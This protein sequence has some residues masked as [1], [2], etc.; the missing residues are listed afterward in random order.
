VSKFHCKFLASLAA[1]LVSAA[2]L[3][4]QAQTAIFVPNITVSSSANPS[5]YGAPL[6]FTVAVTSPVAG[7]QVPTGVVSA[8]LASSPERPAVPGIFSLGGATL[9][10]NGRAQIAVPQPP[11]LFAIAPWGLGAGSNTIAFS[12]SGDTRYGAEQSTFTQFVTLANTKTTASVSGTAQPITLSATVAINEPSATTVAFAI[13]GESSSAPTGTVQFFNGAT[14]VGTATLAPAALFTSTATLAA[15]VTPANLT[16]VY[17]GDANFNPS[18]SA[19]TVQPGGGVVNLTVTS[20]ADP[21]VF[22]A[23]VT[24]SIAA[25]STVAAAPIPTGSVSASLFGL[26]GLGSV[27]LDAAGHGSLAVPPS[28]GGQSAPWGFAAQSNSVTLT[29]SGDSHYAQAQ[30]NFTQVVGKA[31]TTTAATTQVS[32]TAA[33]LSIQATVSINEPSVTSIGFALPGYPAG[34]ANP[35]GSVQFVRNG[36]VVGTAVLSPSGL[37]QSTATLVVTP[38]IPSAGIT[39]VYSGDTNYNGSTSPPATQPSQGVTIGVAS[40][41]NP[42]TFAEPVTFSVTVSP[43]VAGGAVPTGTVAATVLGSD[44]LASATLDATGHAT[45]TVPQTTSATSLPWGLATGTNAITV[46]Y[47]G[48][49]NYV[50]AQTAFNEIVNKANTAT[51]ISAPN[52]LFGA[53]PGVVGVVSI[54]E[55]PVTKNFAI[56]GS[57]NPITNPTGNVA[58]YNGTTLL[59]TVTLSPAELFQST[60][61]LATSVAPTSVVYSGDINYNSSTWT[62]TTPPA[63]AAVVITLASSANPV[64]YGAALTIAATVS[65]AAAGGPTPTGTLT[66][67]DGSQNLG[68][69]A[70]LDSTGRGTMPIPEPLATPL[71]CA[72][73]CPTDVSAMVLSAGSHTITV[74][75]SGDANYRAATSSALSPPVSLVQQI[76]KAPTA[77]AISGT[78]SVVGVASQC[79][80]AASVADGQPPSGGPYHFMTMGASGM[81]DGDPSG[82]V[83]FFNGSTS[84]GTATLSPNAAANVTSTA[85]L[86]ATSAG[87][88]AIYSG[89]ANFQSSTYSPASKGTV[90]LVLTSSPNPSTTGQSV[91]LT[92]TFGVVIA[93]FTVVLPTGTVAFLDG[94]TL[95]GLATVSGTTASLTTTL[96]TAFSTAGPHLLTASYS[97]DA[98]YLATSSASYGQIVNPQSGTLAALTLTANPATAVYGQQIVFFARPVGFGNAPPQGSVTLLDGTTAIGGGEFDLGTAE[99]IVTLPVGTHQLT[100]VWAGDGTWPAAVSPVLSYLVVRAPTVINLAPTTTGAPGQVVLAATVSVPLPG[101]G[102]PTGTVQFIDATT[103][104]V[105]GQASLNGAGATVTLPSASVPPDPIAAVYSGDGNFAPSTTVPPALALVAVSGVT[106]TV[107]APDEI[108]TI[109][110]AN[111]TNSTATGTPPLATSLGGVSVTV[112]D[113]AGTS[114]LAPLYYASPG[115][116]N[117]VVPTGTISGPATLSVAGHSLPIGVTPVSPNLFKVSQVV[118]VLPDGTQTIENTAAPIVFGGDSLYLVLYGTG[119]RN[120]SSLGAVTCT[121]GTLSLPVTYAGPQSQ[122]P[123]LDQVVVPLPASLQGAGAVNAVV[124]ADG[125]ASN[126]VSLT[127]Q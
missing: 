80:V 70:S 82:A 27:T 123:G 26:F 20:S 87:T 19:A 104:A 75:Y 101:A 38:I 112:T 119:I 17:S 100:A 56:P 96:T 8:A 97:G 54:Q 25:V 115:Q 53:A 108:A 32:T 99:A 95:L 63:G 74:S 61:T 76:T 7:S 31:N 2:P 36:T 73:T 94:T 43:A 72:P 93:G 113:A 15:A 121:I 62:S 6:T 11:G 117:F 55:T 86:N 66:F 9:D 42:A 41:A 29:Y 65:P 105:L 58:F 52:A 12:Y 16:A 102:T 4:L 57:G 64:I 125:Y 77:T 44:T 88:S 98:N 118:A 116:I 107:A 83:Q 90:N 14:L 59:G 91:T 114:R 3:R 45:L 126:A 40:S 109:Y 127:F 37:F 68:W 103:Q 85:S 84:L 5:V 120:R 49:S 28:S 111:L 33:G 78:C 51:F 67:F 71:V 46:T 30:T 18:S 110:G 34:S 89:D 106:T 48:D 50:Q 1:V 122:Y 10:A 79:V 47:G 23:P 35:T 22:A 81:V 24:L 13:P 69:I 124:T 60:A 21:S 39:A 92:A